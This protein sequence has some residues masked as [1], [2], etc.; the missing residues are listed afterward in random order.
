MLVMNEND[1][2]RSR[3]SKA[4]EI[5]LLIDRIFKNKG[6][7]LFSIISII[8]IVLSTGLSG[9][10][11]R[12]S[13]NFSYVL[14]CIVFLLIIVNAVYITYQLIRSFYEKAKNKNEKY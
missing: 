14:N 12:L 7:Y 9:M 13:Y 11:S 8:F 6:Y 5:S 2:K 4:D 3:L 10:V 1:E